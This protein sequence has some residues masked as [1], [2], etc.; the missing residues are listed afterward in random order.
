MKI[1]CVWSEAVDGGSGQGRSL[2]E[3]AGA[4]L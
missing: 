1:H 3:T 4:A 2:F